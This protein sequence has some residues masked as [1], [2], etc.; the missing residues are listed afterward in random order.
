MKFTSQVVVTG[1]KASKGTMESGQSFDSTK[2]FLETPLDDSRGTAKGFATADYNLGLS[3]EYEKY[4]HL[5]FPF[6]AEASFEIVTSGKVQKTQLVALKPL[7]SPAKKSA[8]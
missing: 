7:E 5:S 2:V 1:M 4:K 8:S 6:T 3:D